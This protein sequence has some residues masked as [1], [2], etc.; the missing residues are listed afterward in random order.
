MKYCILFVFATFS[1]LALEFNVSLRFQEKP[2][3]VILHTRSGGTVTLGAAK[4][5]FKDKDGDTTPT[6]ESYFV[7]VRDNGY[8][9]IVDTRK[10]PVMSSRLTDVDENKG[11]EVL[12]FYSA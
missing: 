2:E 8:P 9:I 4:L 7:E 11:G 10:G 6:E 3:P 12:L 1:C 5:L